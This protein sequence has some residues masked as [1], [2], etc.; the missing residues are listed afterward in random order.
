[1]KLFRFFIPTQT[2]LQL[3]LIYFKPLSD[4]D[5]AKHNQVQVSISSSLGAVSGEYWA[6]DAE[7]K[8]KYMLRTIKEKRVLSW[9]A[10]VVSISIDWLYFLMQRVAFHANGILF[11]EANTKS[12][13]GGTI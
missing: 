8:T 4:R 12:A 11:D 2:H 9:L 7:G 5:L 13:H 10:D 1:M 3:T 6:L